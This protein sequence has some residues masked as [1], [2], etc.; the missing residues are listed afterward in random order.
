MTVPPPP[1]FRANISLR[2]AVRSVYIWFFQLPLLP[3]LV[4]RADDLA[5]LDTLMRTSTLSGVRTQGPG[6][7]CAE[8]VDAVRWSLSRPGALS[9][10][11]GYYRAL[12]SPGSLCFRMRAGGSPQRPL[13]VPALQLQAAQDPFLGQELPRGSEALCDD[14]TLVTL[15]DCSHWIPSDRW[16][17]A[18]RVIKE[19]LGKREGKKSS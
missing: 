18:V 5:A 12:L 9:G 10:G 14:F 11:L 13:S 7:L 8:D 19:W 17:E 16:K 2:Q 3:E 6:A 1:S 4:L 15:E